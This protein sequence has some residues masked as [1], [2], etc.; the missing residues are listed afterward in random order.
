MFSVEARHHELQRPRHLPGSRHK[1]GLQGVVIHIEPWATLSTLEQPA[2]LAQRKASH[3]ADEPL[4]TRM[5]SHFA[6]LVDPPFE[7][8]LFALPPDAPLPLPLEVLPLSLPFP[9]ALPPVLPE[10]LSLALV[11]DLPLALPLAS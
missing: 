4:R 1:D 7:P 3:E 8:P 6:F 2:P 5:V 9:L 11:F 10:P